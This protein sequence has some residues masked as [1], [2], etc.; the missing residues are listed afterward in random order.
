MAQENMKPLMATTDGSTRVRA[1]DDVKVYAT[2]KLKDLHAVGTELTMHSA[3]AAK[4]EKAGKVTKT[5]PA[6]AKEEPKK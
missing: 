2:D 6:P 1:K 3:L 5:K 4:M